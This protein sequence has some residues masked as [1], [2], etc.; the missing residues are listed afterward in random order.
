MRELWYNHGD[1]PTVL[2]TVLGCGSDDAAKLFLFHAAEGTSETVP[3]SMV[4]VGVRRCSAVPDTGLK[5]SGR[6]GI[7]ALGYGRT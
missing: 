5:R 2:F 4:T 6:A 1:L 7:A 3:A